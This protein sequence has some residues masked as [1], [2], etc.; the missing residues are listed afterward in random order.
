MFDQY[1]ETNAPDEAKPFLANTKASFGMIPNL[2]RTMAAEPTLLSVYSFA[3]DKFNDSPFDDIEQQVIYQTVNFE[4]ECNY[5]VP[6]HTVLSKKAKTPQD[7]IDALRAGTRIS[8]P[9]LEALSEFTRRLL[10]NR[11]K[12]TQGQLEAFFQ[13]GYTDRHALAVVLGIAI[14]TMSNFTNS[15]A[16]TPLDKEV[17][18]YKWRKPT[19][20]I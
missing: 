15:I 1:D 8:D 14:K 4:N 11:G 10:H 6:W 3:W 5:C 17:E 12:I 19:R 2:E 16:E 13:H 20:G 7:I 18:A 9:K